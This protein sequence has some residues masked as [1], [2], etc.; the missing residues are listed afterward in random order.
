MGERSWTSVAETTFT[1]LGESSDFFLGL[2]LNFG[3][4]AGVV[5]FQ[6][7]LVE[8]ALVYLI[9]VAIIQLFFFPIALF[10]PKPVDGQDGDMWDTD[11]T[12]RQLIGLLPPVYWRNIK[13]VWFKAVFNAVI[14]GVIIRTV[15]SGYSLGS[16]LP[17]S[18]GIAIAG[19]VLF[20]LS[21]VWRHFVAEQSYKQKSP[22][23]PLA[24]VYAPL[25]ELYLIFVYVLAP[26]TLVL[27]GIAF[28]I[29]SDLSSLPTL[30]LYLI[31]MGFIRAWIGS[32]DPQTDDF[33]VSFN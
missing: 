29:G 33:E 28:G 4:I 11:P 22:T 21:R 20:Q 15:A 18:V 24:F 6:W 16:D 19:I 26:V 2:I 23:D 9:E 31:P 27:A 10:T 3:L 1:E 25:T 32:L 30:L 17:M 14:V 7:N 8:V 12:P 13:F 5:V